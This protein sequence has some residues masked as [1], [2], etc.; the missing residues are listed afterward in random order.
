MHVH[1]Q[2]NISHKFEFSI[3]Y[4]KCDNCHHRII[5]DKFKN[6]LITHLQHI[7]QI[8]HFIMF[9]FNRNT[10]NYENFKQRHRKSHINK[11]FQYSSFVMKK[12]KRS[13][14]QKIIRIVIYD[15]QISINIKFI[16]RNVHIFS[17]SKFEIY[18]KYVFDHFKFYRT[19]D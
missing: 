14:K 16:D 9:S 3:L 4:K 6:S 12:N 13:N 19:N 2:K 10:K 11:R 1:N 17:F 8:R 18:D 5:I 15:E 7:Q